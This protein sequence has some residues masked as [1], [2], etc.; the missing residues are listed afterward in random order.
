MREWRAS[1]HFNYK[2]PNTKCRRVKSVCA[3][4]ASPQLPSN[5]CAHTK[6]ATICSIIFASSVSS[7][8]KFGLPSWRIFLTSYHLRPASTNQRGRRRMIR[9]CGRT[10]QAQTKIKA[11]ALSTMGTRVNIEKVIMSKNRATRQANEI[12]ANRSWNKSRGKRFWPFEGP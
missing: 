3:S 12:L 6:A 1:Q 11:L 2:R 4:P 8:V 10:R 7:F 5:S 9:F